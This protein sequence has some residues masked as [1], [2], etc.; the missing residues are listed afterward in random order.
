VARLPVPGSDDGTWG[1]ILNDYLSRSLNPDGSLKTSAVSASGAEQTANKDAAGGYAGL[2]GSTKVPIALLPSTALSI[3]SDVNISGPAN[4]QGLIYNSG[5]GK[6]T[7]QALP[8]APVSSVAGKTGAVTLVEGDIASLTAD[9]GA[10]EKTANKGAASGYAGLDSGSKV[11]IANLPTGSTSSTVAI[12]NDAR[13]AGSAAGTAGA[14]L[15]ATDS[16]TTNSRTPSGG[17]SGDLSGTYPSP[18]VAKVNGVSISGTP[19]ANQALIASGSSA[20]TWSA[21]PSAP[22]SSV[23]GKTGAVTLVEG[24]IASLTSDLAATEKTANKGAVSG[25]APLDSGSK[26]PIANLPTGSSSTTVAIGNDARLA[27]ASTAVQSVN[28][29]TGTSITLAPSDIGAIPISAFMAKGDLLAGTGVGASTNLAVGT[30]GQI[31]SA[32]STQTT[33][34]KWATPASAPVTSVAGKTGVVTLAAADVA[35]VEATANKD[36]ANGYAGLD[37]GG[38]LKVAEL[39]SSVALVSS[40]NLFTAAQTIKNTLTEK[41]SSGNTL[42]TLAATSSGNGTFAGAINYYGANGLGT[43]G[44][45]WNTGIDVAAATP[46]RDFFIAK[47]KADNSVQDFFYLMNGGASAPTACIGW[48]PGNANYAFCVSGM[49]AQTTQG[50]VAIRTVSANTGNP[51]VY[52][53]NTMAV[54]TDPASNGGNGGF[55]IKAA[56]QAG[57]TYP[58]RVLTMTDKD[59]TSAYGFYID[60]GGALKLKYYTGGNGIVTFTGGAT[61]WIGT[62]D[63]SNGAGLTIGNTTVAD[64]HNITLGTTNGTKFGLGT[65]QKLAFWNSTPIVQPNTTGTTTGFSAGSGTTVASAST[66]TGNVGATAYTIGDVVNALKNLGLMAA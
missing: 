54:T 5:S 43:N 60:T 48:T 14:A 2:D 50:G 21:L 6:W 17:A 45:A 19:S 22:V 33:G 28:S 36:V 4:N 47:V 37:S 9:L 26:V 23:A 27:A 35:G 31:L 3:A 46:Y 16:T 1:N 61:T 66:F 65:N 10:T 53:D 38:L 59:G 29:K 11:P 18:A 7:N 40:A 30:N 39:P 8:S 49:D 57:S 63:F 62:M 41:D 55:T 51:W 15:S 52:F 34:V 56:Q 20:A 42:V 13:F 12:G 24:D 64:N 32:D 58:R 44:I 25:Y